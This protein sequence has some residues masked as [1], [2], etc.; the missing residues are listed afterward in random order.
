MTSRLRAQRHCRR[1]RKSA[2]PEIEYPKWDGG[3]RINIVFFGLRGGESA[4]DEGCPHCTD[5]IMVFTIDPVSKT[6]GHDLRAPG[7][8]R[9]HPRQQRLHAAQD[10]FCRI[11]TAWTTGEAL[12]AAGRRARRWR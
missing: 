1:R 2:A 9:E 11:N 7:S 12:A 6:G 4:A 5:T 10:G 3:S 8:V